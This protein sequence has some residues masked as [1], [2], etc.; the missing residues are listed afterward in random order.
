MGQNSRSLWPH[1]AYGLHTSLYADLAEEDVALLEKA[2]FLRGVCDFHGSVMIF[3]NWSSPT[4]AHPAVALEYGLTLGLDGRHRKAGDI[5]Q[6]AL[7]RAQEDNPD[8]VAEADIYR[9]IRMHH[10]MTQIFSHGKLGPAWKSMQDVRPWLKQVPIR[11]YTD[12]QVSAP[13]QPLYL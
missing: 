13:M 11:E 8:P 3:E 9:L 6:A 2:I 12:I 10:G 7:L 5:F 4:K 1:T